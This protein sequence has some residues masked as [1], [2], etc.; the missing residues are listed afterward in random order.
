M[1]KADL[2]DFRALGRVF[3][4]LGD[5]YGPQNA[6]DNFNGPMRS[7]MVPVLKEVKSKTPID[8][9]AL[10]ASV[11]GL[12]GPPTK[13]SLTVKPD[14]IFSYRVGYFW[15]SITASQRR[16]ALA[17][18]Y[19]TSNRAGKA[20]LRNALDRHKEQ[21]ISKFGREIGSAL[22]KKAIQLGNKRGI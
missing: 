20:V 7:A 21:V 10:R 15:R 18:E 9:G 11:R 13:R 22:E 8:T 19:G 3:K 5:E 17:L 1:F 4:D 12:G 14:V 6:R 16:K 2:K